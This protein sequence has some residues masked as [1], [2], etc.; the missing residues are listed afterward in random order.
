M[1][2]AVAEAPPAADTDVNV[3][4]IWV[5][6]LAVDEVVLI[7]EEDVVAVEVTGGGFMGVGSVGVG[8]WLLDEEAALIT[9]VDEVLEGD[10][11]LNV[12]MTDPPGPSSST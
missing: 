4:D 12:I 10:M 11:V 2:E 8:L 9:K 6:L 5:G 7:A 1:T 3:D